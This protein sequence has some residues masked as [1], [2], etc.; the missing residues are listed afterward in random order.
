MGKVEV[1]SDHSITELWRDMNSDIQG[2]KMI[3]DDS[4]RFDGLCVRA[5]QVTV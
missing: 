3:K 2:N 5:V 1:M 4:E